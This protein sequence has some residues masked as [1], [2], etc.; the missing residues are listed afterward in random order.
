MWAIVPIK[1]FAQAKR[2]LAPVLSA[3]ERRQLMLAMARDVLA[4]LSQSQRL[5]GVLL[6]SRAAEAPDLAKAF[7]AQLFRESADA[8]LPTALDEARQHAADNLGAAGV[9]VVPA[10]APLI[11]GREIDEILASHQAITL[12]PDREQVG[13]NGLVCT[14]PQAIPLVFD[15]R[16]FKPHLA[17][18]QASGLP[19]RILP[20]STFALDID[21]PTDLVELLR[22]G[23]N[24]QTGRCLRKLGVAE[25]LIGPSH[26]R[27]Q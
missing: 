26:P 23:P 4:A 7:A 19:W 2:R 12:L 1:S 9:F 24:T 13:T 27:T 15:G 11:E 16:S 14:P 22:K 3:A 5:S 6:A 8:N 25:R 20:D 10:D 18:A 17:H 21:T